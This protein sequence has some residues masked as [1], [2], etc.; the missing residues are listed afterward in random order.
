[1]GRKLHFWFSNMAWL[2]LRGLILKV[3]LLFLCATYHSKRYT[4]KRIWSSGEAEGSRWSII[5]N[6]HI[7]LI[8]IKSGL[9]LRGFTSSLDK[10][11]KRGSTGTWKSIVKMCNVCLEL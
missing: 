4:Q 1:M 3:T 6:G 7:D 10:Y 11:L 8:F 9:A 2:V 5:L